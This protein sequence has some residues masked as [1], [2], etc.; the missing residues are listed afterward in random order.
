MKIISA[1]FKAGELLPSQYTCDGADVNPPLAFSA[2]PTGTKSLVLICSDPDAVGGEW[3]HWL[4]WNI[5]PKINSI[6]E[7]SVP[8]GAVLGTT[9]FGQSGYGGPCPPSGV[10][11]YYF[12]LYALDIILSLGPEAEMEQLT[13]A[14]SG[15]ILAEAELLGR[16]GR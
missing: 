14:L 13:Q 5:G 1:A 15:H 10:H 8:A 4:V 16:Y 9:S 3:I 11:R 7:N 6:A 2:V 12:K